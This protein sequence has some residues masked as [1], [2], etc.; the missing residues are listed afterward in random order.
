MNWSLPHD[1]Y[2]AHGRII[3]LTLSP[4]ISLLQVQPN[5]HRSLPTDLVEKLKTEQKT[6]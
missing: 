2:V 6:C 4:R 1:D 5:T 3:E